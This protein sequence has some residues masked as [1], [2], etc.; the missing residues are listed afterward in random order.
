MNSAHGEKYLKNSFD[1][2]DKNKDGDIDISELY[3]C[4]NTMNKKVS[5]GQILRLM[6]HFDTNEEL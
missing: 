4:I 1:V 2:F 3:T 6:R 5:Y